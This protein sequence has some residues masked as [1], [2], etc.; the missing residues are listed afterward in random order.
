[1]RVSLLLH[2]LCGILV[3]T[4]LFFLHFS[5]QENECERD[6]LRCKE[7]DEKKAYSEDWLDDDNEDSQGG[8]DEDIWEEEDYIE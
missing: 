2:A 7:K 5:W 8:E 1:M 6:N 4:S 3:Y